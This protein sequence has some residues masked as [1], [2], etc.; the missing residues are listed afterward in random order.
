MRLLGEREVNESVYAMGRGA[1]WSLCVGG[2]PGGPATDAASSVIASKARGGPGLGMF[3]GPWTGPCRCAGERSLG[4]QRRGA[5]QPGETQVRGVDHLLGMTRSVVSIVET[6][7][8]LSED[9][10][11]VRSM[12]SVA[13]GARLGAVGCEGTGGVP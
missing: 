9:G 13:T 5:W 3:L 4:D 1:E 12:V 6:D 11:L 2:G 8:T 7:A 10:V